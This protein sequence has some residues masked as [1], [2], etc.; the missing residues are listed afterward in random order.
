MAAS[1]LDLNP[2]LR[3]VIVD[4]GLGLPEQRLFHGLQ[5]AHRDEHSCW[6]AVAGDGDPLLL[7]EVSLSTSGSLF[8]PQLSDTGGLHQVAS[9][10]VELQEYF[11][12]G[13]LVVRAFEQFDTT[14]SGADEARIWWVDAD[15]VLIGPHP[16]TPQG[17]RRRSWPESTRPYERSAAYLTSIR[18]ICPPDRARRASR[19][20]SEHS[21]ASA[22]AT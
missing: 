21:R 19:V 5:V 20:S 12:T 2:R 14:P 18:A 8:V 17:A 7:R 9:R 22:R 6:P 1:L 16:D 11:L 10:F 15:P 13:G 3:K 4:A